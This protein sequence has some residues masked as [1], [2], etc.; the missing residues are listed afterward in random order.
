MSL[1][2]Y[3]YELEKTAYDRA[4]QCEEMDSSVENMTENT[5]NYTDRLN[6]SLETAA[7]AAVQLWWSELQATTGIDQIQ[8]LFFVHAGFQSFAKI[9]SDLTTGVGCGIVRCQ[10]LINIVCHYETSVM[11]IYFAL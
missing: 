10:T 7:T 6:S 9:A 11:K 8:N 1:Q 5:H 4:K 2:V 3:C